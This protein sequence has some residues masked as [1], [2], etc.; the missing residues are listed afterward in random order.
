[1]RIILKKLIKS[2]FNIFFYSL[3]YE[4]RL[5]L[6]VW[7]LIRTMKKIIKKSLL[8]VE[9]EIMKDYRKNNR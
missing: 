1:M 3:F 4:L 5:I 6:G 2:V 8:D 7:I 9:I